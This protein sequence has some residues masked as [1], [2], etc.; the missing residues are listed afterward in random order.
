MET[1]KRRLSRN[2]VSFLGSWDSENSSMEVKHNSVGVACIELYVRV[3][4]IYRIRVQI[5]TR[6]CHS[7][8]LSIQSNV[9]SNNGSVGAVSSR[10]ELSIGVRCE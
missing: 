3:A 8:L 4:W 2:M 7:R 10:Q 6:D 5:R 9:N 1:E